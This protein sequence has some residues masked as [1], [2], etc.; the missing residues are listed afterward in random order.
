MVTAI[1]GITMTLGEIREVSQSISISVEEQG[2][3]TA[4]I[5]RN[6]QGAA[7]GTSALTGDVD[8]VAV[9]VREAEG[10]ARSVRSVSDELSR[11]AGTLRSAVEDFL[12][13][14]RVA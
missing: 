12:K 1:E 3:A 13:R 5:S 14:V 6:A 7:E 10:A 4:E 9:T 8:D 11:E 2:V